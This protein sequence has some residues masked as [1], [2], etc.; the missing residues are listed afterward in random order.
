MSMYPHPRTIPILVGQPIDMDSGFLEYNK[1]ILGFRFSDQS[2]KHAQNT[3][4]ATLHVKL[5]LSKHFQ[6]MSPALCSGM[7]YVPHMTATALKLRSTCLIMCRTHTPAESIENTQQY[8]HQMGLT[9]LTYTPAMQCAGNEDIITMKAEDAGDTV[10]FMFESPS[11][12]RI[13]GASTIH[14]PP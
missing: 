1:Y 8:M 2:Y 5:M 12:D 7:N 6:L 10:S 13:A 4:A 14:P 9:L 3:R 11:Q